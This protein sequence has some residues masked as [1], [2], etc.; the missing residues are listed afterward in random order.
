MPVLN[1]SQTSSAQPT[2]EVTPLVITI[3]LGGLFVLDKVML[4]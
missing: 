1:R 4:V 2:G 3:P